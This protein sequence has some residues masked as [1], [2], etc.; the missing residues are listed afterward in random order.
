MIRVVVY[1]VCDYL[2]LPNGGEVML[3]NNF[4]SANKSESIEYYLVGMSFNES[5]R[6]GEWNDKKIGN[7]VYKF[8]PVS[9]VLVDK[10]KTHIPFRLRMVHGIKKYWN[11][12]EKVNADYHYIHSA[13]L[14]MPL[15][16]KD[17]KLVYHVH[18]DPCQTMKISRFPIFRLQIFTDNYWKIIAKTVEKS[19]KI[20]WA[21]D[22][23]KQLYLEQ[24]PQM[25][26]VVN[27][28]S[29][30]IH[31][32]FDT[33]LVVDKKSIPT[34]TNRKHLVTVGRVSHVKR[35]DFLIDVANKLIKE[36]QD[37]DLLICGD[38]EEKK[39]LEEKAKGLGISDRIVFLGLF[40][41]VQIATVLN[42]SDVFVFA[43]EN[44][45]MS[46]VV[47]E[48]LYMGIPVVSTNVGDIPYAV[49]NGETGYIVD[50]YDVKQY[51]DKVKI[52]LENGKESYLE[53][54]KKMAMNFTPD[55]M[56][57]RINE[58]FNESEN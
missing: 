3:L 52:I 10:E 1:A 23:S 43:S 5:D 54:C 17:I 14:A 42:D 45:A 16:K 29:I 57:N 7:L 12:I 55:I 24:Q 6:V 21:A 4:L 26:D 36:G 11:K 37:I 2:T 53:A 9:Q 46:L 35:M 33:K 22:R 50:G 25:K 48:S 47:L 34:L 38:G 39:A 58:V 28:K 44:E 32:S 41:R 20:V 19:Y 18:G 56:A 27:R 8:L 13:E 40:N 30:T 31:S 15:W 51:A 49:K